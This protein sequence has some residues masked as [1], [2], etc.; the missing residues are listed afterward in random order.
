MWLKEDHNGNEMK[1]IRGRENDQ[2]I[3]KTPQRERGA[4]PIVL[5][6]SISK[7]AS[8]HF[9]KNLV[10]GDPDPEHGKGTL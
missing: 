2:N 8:K 3:R 4:V 1:G 7:V 5:L 10:N 6:I 9:V